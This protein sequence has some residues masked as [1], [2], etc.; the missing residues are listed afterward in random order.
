MKNTKQSKAALKS[1]ETIRENQY[2]DN[3]SEIADKAVR[4]RKLSER[5]MKAWITRKKNQASK[6]DGI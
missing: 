5:A 4:T 3:L 1:W 6:I 2:E